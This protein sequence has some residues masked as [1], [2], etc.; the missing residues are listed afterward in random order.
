MNKLSRELLDVI[1]EFKPAHPLKRDIDNWR[2][3]GKRIPYFHK[4]YFK[5]PKIIELQTK[6]KRIEDD[7]R[8]QFRCMLEDG[9]TNEQTIKLNYKNKLEKQRLNK[10]LAELGLEKY[11]ISMTTH[12]PTLNKH[13]NFSEVHHNKVEIIF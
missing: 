1:E 2:R 3:C 10:K 4:Y 13:G 6:K 8:F 7:R 12:F 11:M 9:F 5:Q